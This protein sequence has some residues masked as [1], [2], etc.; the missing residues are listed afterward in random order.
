MVLGSLVNWVP[1]TV[2][3]KSRHKECDAD[4]VDM[5]V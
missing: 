2:S 1:L 3:W 5:G 4:F